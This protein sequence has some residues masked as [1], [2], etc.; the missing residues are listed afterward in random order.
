M[1]SNFI[2]RLKKTAD[3]IFRENKN[4]V[5]LGEYMALCNKKDKFKNSESIL[6]SLNKL[7]KRWLGC[8]PPLLTDAR[9][10]PLNCN[11][12]PIAISKRSLLHSHYL[13]QLYPQWLLSWIIL[14]NE[15]HKYFLMFKKV[16][17]LRKKNVFFFFFGYNNTQHGRL[18]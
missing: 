7:N 4:V 3:E 16:T 13:H 1:A 2:R 10:Q 5:P 12:I 11:E 8:S 14:T 15:I 18:I 17:S 6:K 9:Q